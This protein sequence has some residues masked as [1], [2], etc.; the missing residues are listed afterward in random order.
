MSATQ[1]VRRGTAIQRGG[2][3]ERPRLLERLRQLLGYRL[4]IITA[5]PGFGKTTLLTQ[6]VRVTDLPVAWQTLDER[7]RDLP[8]LYAQSIQAL[9]TVVPALEGLVA[10]AGLGAAELAADLAVRLAGTLSND[11][12]YVLDD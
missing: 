12:L 9:T 5:P 7:S 3:I 2:F 4:T 6:L 1:A 8:N 11:V 10:P